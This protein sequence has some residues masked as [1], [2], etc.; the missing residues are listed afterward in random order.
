MVL[1][2]IFGFGLSQPPNSYMVNRHFEMSLQPLLDD[3]AVASSF[4]GRMIVVAN[5]H[6]VSHVI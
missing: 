3:V 4:H 2:K 1:G 5:I 6:L